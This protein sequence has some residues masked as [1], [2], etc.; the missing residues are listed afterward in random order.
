MAQRRA[1]LCEEAPRVLRA[2]QRVGPHGADPLAR[3]VPDPLSELPQALQRT[4]ARFGAETVRGIETGG[5]LDHLADAV[6]D[7]ELIGMRP[8]DDQVEARG[9]EID[10]GNGLR[11]GTVRV[12]H[13]AARIL[14][15]LKC[16]IHRDL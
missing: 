3:E 10:G 5:E 2:A 14:T 12:H 4:R 8:R 16:P 6:D 15:D 13:G 11:K 1:R 7:H 9:A